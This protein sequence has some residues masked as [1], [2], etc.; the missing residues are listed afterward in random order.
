MSKDVI[1]DRYARLYEIPQQLARLGHEVQAF[2]LAYQGQSQG[3]WTHDCEPGSVTWHSTPLNL[4]SIGYPRTLLKTLSQYKP[5]VLIAASDIPHI[6]IGG[7]IARKLAIPYFVDLYDNFE[8]FGQARIPFFVSLLRRVTARARLVTTTS[9]LLKDYVLRHYFP[10]GRVVAMPSAV[11]TEVF[12]AR[13]KSDCREELGLPKDVKLI[14]T[15]G[16]LYKEKGIELLLDAWQR[17]QHERL[18]VHLV[19]AGPIEKGLELPTGPRVHCLG[20][21]PHETVAKLFCSLD[22]GVICVLDSVFGRYSFPQKAY[23]MLACYLPLVVSD[24]GAMGQL[25]AKWPSCLAKVGDTEDMVEKILAQLSSPVLP[26]I[27]IKDW[28]GQVEIIDQAIR[29]LDRS[30]S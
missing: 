11:D 23:E 2:C 29:Q 27:D 9:D 21:L 7:Y 5:D 12:C 18:D 16:G 3:E 1:D 19:L 28:R 8:G 10:Q 4:K 17:I 26:D 22:V 13:S 30:C 6:V 24:V 20:L 25:F 14:G 15:A